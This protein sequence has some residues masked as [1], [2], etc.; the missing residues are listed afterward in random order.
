MIEN[1]MG[2]ITV[3][4]VPLDQLLAR[5]RRDHVTANDVA[6]VTKEVIEK[7]ETGEKLLVIVTDRAATMKAA[8]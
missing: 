4:H 8:R 5:D 3:A 2:P 6:D 1:Q 7:F